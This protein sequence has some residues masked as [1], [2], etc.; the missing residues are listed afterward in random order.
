MNLIQL[1]QSLKIPKSYDGEKFET[2]VLPGYPK[3]RI[4][5]NSEGLPALLLNIGQSLK[6]ADNKN[7]KLKHLLIQHGLKC[8]VIEKDIIKEEWLTAIKFL[9]TDPGLQ[10]FFLKI[11]ENLILSMGEFASTSELIYQINKFAELFR[12]MSDAPKK[13]IQGLW[14]EL[15]VIE[16]SFNPQNLIDYW[17]NDPLEKF[18]FNASTE[19]VEVKTSTNFERIHYFSAEQLDDSETAEIIIASVFL[20]QSSM[21]LNIFQLCEMIT[22]KIDNDIYLTEKITSTVFHTLGSLIEQA[23]EIKYD[24][25]LACESLAFFNQRDIKRISLK[26]IPNEISNIKYRS[27][28]SRVQPIKGINY[29]KFKRLISSCVN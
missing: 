11:A 29:Q 16:R 14:G 23:I 19:K 18:D 15:L 12:A 25:V 13:T 2:E 3:F 6:D 26:N 5:V 22:S 17:H 4:A 8:K 9:S 7:L 28:L 1:F 10:H 27:D 21:G 20:R 24:Y